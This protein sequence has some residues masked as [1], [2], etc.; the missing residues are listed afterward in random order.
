MNKKLCY[1]LTV[2]MASILIIS[3]GMKVHQSLEDKNRAVSYENASRFANLSLPEAAENE[4]VETDPVLEALKKID[5]KTL[6]EV[7]PDVI[8]WICIPDTVVSYPLLK[9]ED[10]D[11]YLNHTWEGEK[12]SGGSIF[13]DWRNSSDLTDFNTIIYGHRMRDESMFGALKYY[14][15]QEFWKEHPTIYIA[16]SSGVHIYNIFAAWEPQVSSIV[17][18]QD[19][20]TEEARQELLDACLAGTEL[21]T[22]IIPDQE[23]RILT[24]STCTGL[25]YNARW[26][27]QGYLVREYTNDT[28]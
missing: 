24:L 7:N 25:G 16:D 17:Y 12:R 11:F 10:N 1:A 8:G 22:G 5:L 18:T 21:D 6:Q 27:V 14:K 3:V 26:V 28:N 4:N 15:T 19:F 20:D 23:D 2:A 9:G 13:M